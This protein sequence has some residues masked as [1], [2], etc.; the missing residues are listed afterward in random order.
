MKSEPSDG[1]PLTDCHVL[2]LEDDVSLGALT[3]DILL[4]IGVAS[5]EHVRTIED[6]LIEL[7]QERYALCI[8]DSRIGQRFSTPV[9]NHAIAKQIP[10]LLTSGGDLPA[11]LADRPGGLTFLR[12]P[13]SRGRW[14]R[15]LD[16]VVGGSTG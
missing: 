2:L 4:D 1:I 9:V 16:D 13:V 3:V 6:A 11:E 10:L 15:A 14:R 7:D 5:V 8:I 12:K